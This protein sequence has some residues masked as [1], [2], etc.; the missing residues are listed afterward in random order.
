MTDQE[1]L[2]WQ[3]RCEDLGETSFPELAE[4]VVGYMKKFPEL[5]EAS[6]TKSPKA[7]KAAMNLRKKI[8]DVFGDADG[9]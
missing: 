3:L 6:P 7:T 9:S 1:W 5:F 2:D 4:A 8:K